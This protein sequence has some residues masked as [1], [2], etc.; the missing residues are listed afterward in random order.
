M[1]KSWIQY[2]SAAT[3]LNKYD[4]N[5]RTF[6]AWLLVCVFRHVRRAVAKI[7]NCLCH[8]SLSARSRAAPTEQILLKFHIWGFYKNSLAPFDVG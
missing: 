2:D 8:V 7:R 5:V 3:R 1:T 4:L 6:C